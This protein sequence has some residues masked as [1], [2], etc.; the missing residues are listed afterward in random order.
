MIVLL[1]VL[2]GCHDAVSSGPSEVDESGG[3]LEGLCKECE[4]YGEGELEVVLL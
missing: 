1:P 4:G 3:D 2:F